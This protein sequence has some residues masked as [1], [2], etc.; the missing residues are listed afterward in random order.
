M[1]DE[2]EKENKTRNDEIIIKLF[3]LLFLIVSISFSFFFLS[4]N[5]FSI[6][7]GIAFFVFTKTDCNSFLSSITTFLSG[8][9]L[10]NFTKSAFSRTF[11][12]SSIVSLDN[13]N[14]FDFF[15]KIIFSISSFEVLSKA[16]I[17]T[18]FSK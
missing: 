13:F 11:L 18:S 6:S 12:K 5:S 10:A 7:F 4:S 3:F 2:I 16:L 15:N 17:S 1:Y 8:V 9:Y 14:F